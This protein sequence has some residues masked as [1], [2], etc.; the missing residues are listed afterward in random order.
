[1]AVNNR[2][3]SRFG[4]KYNAVIKNGMRSFE[5][6][7]QNLSAGGAF[8][9]SEEELKPDQRIHLTIDVQQSAPLQ[10]DATV[11]WVEESENDD[12]PYPYSAGVKF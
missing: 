1:L 2:K 5:G 4:T 10:M 11:V 7:V 12:Q 8:I 9:Y 6:L 3:Y